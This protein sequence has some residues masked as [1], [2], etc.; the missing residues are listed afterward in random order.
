MNSLVS[1]IL[2]LYNE[3][4]EF[5]QLAINSILNQTYKNIE[6]ILLLDNPNN[7]SLKDLIIQ[8]KEKDERVKYNFNEINLGLP[9]T[10]N[11]GI[12]LS[13]G[14]Y[15]ARMD[16]D[17]ISDGRRLEKQIKFLIE[18]NDI[19]LLGSDAYAINEDGEII[20]KY[21]KLEKDFSQ[22][23]MLKHASINLIH[24][25]WIGKSKVFQN[26]MYR[27]YEH[28][29]DY[30]FMIRAYAL[31]YNFYNLKEMLFY[32]RIQQK[33]LRS[34]SRKNAYEQY[35]NTKRL[36]KQF[37]KYLNNRD[38]KSLDMPEFNYDMKDKEKYQSTI[39]LLNDL[40]EAFFSKKIFDI[41]ILFIKIAKV[42]I[43][44]LSFRFRVF[45]ISKFLFAL[46]RFKIV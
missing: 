4:V 28:C 33:S 10:L 18:H 21:I 23:F 5:A 2:P 29:E 43:R 20:G 7:S 41:I 40:R 44:P 11:I 27:N 37:K 12:K 34:V 22:K 13:T 25:T 6:L 32:V 45:F 31:G 46:E 30:D 16:G 35:I 19:D 9:E 42:D 39:G 1:V 3:P 8:Y 15:I 24:P 26:C 36:Q 38:L 17:D 14:E